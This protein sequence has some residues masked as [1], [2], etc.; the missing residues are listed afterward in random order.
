MLR[1]SSRRFFFALA[2]FLFIFPAKSFAQENPSDS[3]KFLLDAVN[4]ERTSEN[5]Q[6][7]KWNASL[8]NAARLHLHKMVE[9]NSLSHQ[10]SGEPD[11]ARRLREAGAHFSSIAE[12]IAE[13]PSVSELHIGWMNSIPH[14]NNIMNPKFTAIGIAIE[15]RGTQYFAVQ[16]FSVAV[17]AFTKE[18]Q[19]KKVGQLLQ[20]RGLKIETNSEEARKACDSSSGFSGARPLATIHFETPDLSQLPDQLVS[21]AKSGRYRVAAVGACKADESAGFSRF[22]ISVLLY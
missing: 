11:L 1:N 8:A 16:D 10:F 9:R 18:E 13:A 17:N 12:N 21:A 15:M 22:R 7:L 14:R 6:P 2:F 4:R 3:E 5:L 20:A 19:E